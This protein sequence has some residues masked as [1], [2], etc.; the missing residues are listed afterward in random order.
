MHNN[1]EFWWQGGGGK[2]GKTKLWDAGVKVE[3]GEA[4]AGLHGWH[5]VKTWEPLLTILGVQP[6]FGRGGLKPL[7]KWFVGAI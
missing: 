1:R 2:E 4:K 3:D 7:A 6:E 5:K